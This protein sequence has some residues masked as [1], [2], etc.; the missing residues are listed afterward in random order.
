M[1]GCPPGNKTI[2]MSNL[3]IYY[4]NEVVLVFQT[5]IKLS[6]VLGFLVFPRRLGTQRVKWTLLLS[7]WHNYI[8]IIIPSVRDDTKLADR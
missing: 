8:G 1:P 3:N 5:A 4:H 7:H 2:E 6:A